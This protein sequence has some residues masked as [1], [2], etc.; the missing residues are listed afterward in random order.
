[1]NPRT[2]AL[3]QAHLQQSLTQLQSIDTLSSEV[4][5]FMQWLDTQSISTLISLERIQH[6]AQIYALDHP[7][8]DRLRDDVV[9]IIQNA[10]DHPSNQTTQLA[11]IIPT[12]TIETAA[13]YLSEQKQHRETLIHEIFNNPAYAQMLSQTISHAITDYME[14][15]VIA[16]K[17]PGMGSLMKLGKSALESAT[18]SNLDSALQQYLNKN[19][20]NLIGISE[21]MANKHLN[22]AQVYAIIIQAWK[23]IGPQKISQLR[24]YAPAQ[25]VQETAVMVHDTWNHLRTTA[26]IQQQVMDGIANWYSLNQA[27]SPIAILAD[28]NVSPQTIRTEL[29]HSALPII[30]LAVDSGYPAQRIEIL[31]RDFYESEAAQQILN[32]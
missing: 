3:I 13:R 28:F 2:D 5:A 24:Q 26:F 31:L 23:K 16:K 11:D 29:Q 22:D 32:S 17:V 19:I 10:L 15:N 8:T 30:Q 1:M 14:N 20:N 27:R 18:N 7:L 21:K 25:T 9:S 6:L 4:D 12:Q